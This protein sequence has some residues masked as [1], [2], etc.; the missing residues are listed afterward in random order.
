MKKLSLIALSM[1]MMNSA[2]NARE[3]EGEMS[4][5]EME[6][7][8]QE[9]TNQIHLDFTDV[10]S[11]T[12]TPHGQ[13]KSMSPKKTE[14]I[15]QIKGFL[16]DQGYL[17]GHVNP[18]NIILT[19]AGSNV[20]LS[21]DN[22]TVADY[23]DVDRPVTIK[24]TGKNEPVY[25]SGPAHGLGY[26]DEMPTDQDRPKMYPAVM[27]N[28]YDPGHPNQ[29]VLTPY[30]PGALRP[31]PSDMTDQDRPKEYSAVMPSRTAVY[32][33]KKGKVIIRD[34]VTSLELDN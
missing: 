6:A 18:D 25:L 27:P 22:K 10:L 33:A 24:V 21:D 14:T 7:Q 1:L 17:K 34:G 31:I 32:P 30:V 15:G 28:K 2:M 11:F 4:A 13:A 8:K 16:A 23:T 3:V 9:R 5:Q 29:P 20:V 26:R 12:D 19:L